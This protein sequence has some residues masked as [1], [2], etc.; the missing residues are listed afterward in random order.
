MTIRRQGRIPVRL[1]ERLSSGNPRWL[2]ATPGLPIRCS[3]GGSENWIACPTPRP[4]SVSDFPD[5]ISP[6]SGT[7]HSTNCHNGH[8]PRHGSPGRAALPLPHRF[9]NACMGRLGG[10]TAGNAV[11]RWQY[12]QKAS[13]SG[14]TSE[15]RCVALRVA[16]E[17]CYGIE[18]ELMRH[19]FPNGQPTP[20]FIHHLPLRAAASTDVSAR[21]SMLEYNMTRGRVA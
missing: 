9:E 8:E 2:W 13:S 12:D 10:V 3:D 16:L 15:S 18:V 20:R 11:S 4:G 5:L 6:S 1:L 21:S 7:A 14:Q 17:Y 19:A